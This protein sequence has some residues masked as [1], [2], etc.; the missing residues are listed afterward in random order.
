MKKAAPLIR[1]AFLVLFFILLRN[2]LLLVWLVLYL[3]SLIFPLLFGKRL[4]CV[5]ACPMNT[6]MVWVVKLKAKLGRGNKPAPNWL[7]GKKAAYVSLAATIA[8]FFLSRKFLGRDLP[9]MLFWML[10]SVLLTWNHHPDVF[11]D[12]L[13]PYG[14]AQGCL[15]KKSLLSEEGRREANNYQGFTA[16]VLGGGPGKDKPGIRKQQ[17]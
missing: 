9:V 7:G 13:C 11:H 15:A 5:L 3:V 2:R 16:S 1:I 6:L 17:G 8:L 14:V 10:A 12:Q 4:Y